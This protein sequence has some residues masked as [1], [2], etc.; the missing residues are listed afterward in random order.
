[1]N[2]FQTYGNPGPTEPPEAEITQIIEKRG[3]KRA[4]EL[5]VNIE[6]Q[7]RTFLLTL[8]ALKG[9]GLSGPAAVEELRGIRAALEALAPLKNSQEKE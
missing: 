3:G 6:G 2:S 9:Y 4:L 8:D 1:M 5:Q 7:H